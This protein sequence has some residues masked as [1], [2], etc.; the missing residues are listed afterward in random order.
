MVDY[1]GEASARREALLR[2]GTAAAMAGD[3]A[4][5]RSILVEQLGMSDAA[6]LWLAE[7]G[8]KIAASNA[9]VEENGLPLAKYRM[10]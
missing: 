4:T 8:D 1:D 10:F 9:W 5:G 6:V 2:R 3:L 7:N